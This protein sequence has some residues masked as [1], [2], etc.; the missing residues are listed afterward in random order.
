MKEIKILLSWL[1]VAAYTSLW[2]LAGMVQALCPPRKDL[3]AIWVLPGMATVTLI[4]LAGLYLWDH[5]DEK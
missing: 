3:S 5:W 4:V 1:L 2:W